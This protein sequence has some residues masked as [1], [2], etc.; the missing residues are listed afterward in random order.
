MGKEERYLSSMQV[1]DVDLEVPFIDWIIRR[2]FKLTR[3]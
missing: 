2:E 3:K 1:R